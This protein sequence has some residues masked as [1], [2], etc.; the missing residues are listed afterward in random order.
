MSNFYLPRNANYIKE[1]DVWKW[2]KNIYFELSSN[3]L[4]KREKIYLREYY[5]S[6]GLLKKWRK[7]Y[8]RE[9]FSK[10]F[11]RACNFLFPEKSYP[12]ILDL[13]GGL[14]T[15]SLFMAIR[16]AEVYVLDLDGFALN[17]HKKRK[18]FYEEEIQQELD[19]HFMHCDA[20]S[21][22]Y[23]QV[24]PFDG[25]YS[26]F[27]F[28]MMQPSK[29]LLRVLLPHMSANSKVV[30]Q[31]GNVNS[32]VSK[33]LP[34]RRRDALSPED[35]LTILDTYG[36]QL[37]ELSGC[38]VMPPLFWFLFPKRIIR[39]FDVR[40]RVNLNLPVSYLLLSEKR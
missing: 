30:I 9:H 1:N 36:Y 39:Y 19:V 35:L 40:L 22:P 11:T 31:D 27:A 34:W 16:G 3:F 32:I 15:Q 38:V 37:N 14:G 4:S 29:E 20:F 18:R 26:L 10:P 8:F 6:A 25:L 12:K 21:A 23:D 28:N 7:N 17:I 13:G 24:G 33:T 2:Y 5:L